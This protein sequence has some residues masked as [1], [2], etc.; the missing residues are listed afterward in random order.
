MLYQHAGLNYLW[1]CGDVGG[2]RWQKLELPD[3]VFGIRREFFF[4]N[5]HNLTFEWSDIYNL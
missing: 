2:Y 5:L 4:S 3:S 1:F